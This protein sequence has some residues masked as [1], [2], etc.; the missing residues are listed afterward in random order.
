MDQIYWLMERTKTYRALIGEDDWVKTEFE[1]RLK[2]IDALHTAVVVEGEALIS[3]MIEHYE[4]LR[5]ERE[6]GYESQVRVLNGE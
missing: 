3:E 6:E 1:Q 4:A 2:A 5:K